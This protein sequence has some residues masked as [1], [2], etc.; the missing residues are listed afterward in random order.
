M[1]SIKIKVCYDSKRSPSVVVKHMPNG[2]C[3]QLYH[4]KNN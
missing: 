3:Y 4:T 2:L 1:K